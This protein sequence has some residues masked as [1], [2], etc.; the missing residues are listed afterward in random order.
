MSYSL[1]SEYPIDTP[2]VEPYIIRIPLYN[3][4]RSL[5]IVRVGFSQ[6]TVVYNG[7]AVRFHAWLGECANGGDSNAGLKDPFQGN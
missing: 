5:D 2:K 4:V 7:P 1:N 6:R 3:L